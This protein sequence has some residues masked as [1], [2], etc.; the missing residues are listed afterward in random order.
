MR[1]SASTEGK[2]AEVCLQNPVQLVKALEQ[3]TEDGLLQWRKPSPDVA[4]TFVLGGIYDIL[5]E[6]YEPHG[7]TA[8]NLSVVQYR[9]GY[10]LDFNDEISDV[11]LAALWEKVQGAPTFE[12]DNMLFVRL[13][14]HESAPTASEVIKKAEQ[15]AEPNSVVLPRPEVVPEP[16]DVPFAVEGRE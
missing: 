11:S 15:R 16:P 8:Y 4:W 13:D 7:Q 3:D 14:K 6:R 9:R 10:V 12:D 1:R 2:M 5:L